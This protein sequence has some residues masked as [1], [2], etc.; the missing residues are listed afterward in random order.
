MPF[1][2][3]LLPLQLFHMNHLSLGRVLLR[4]V[5]LIYSMWSNGMQSNVVQ[6]NR[7]SIVTNVAFGNLDKMYLRSCKS[8]YVG[9]IDI[10]NLFESMILTP[11]AASTTTTIKL[12]W[13]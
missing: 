9:Y 7:E 10:H 11:F 13:G 3:V 5:Y 2:L 6:A 12:C 4:V 8:L 1:S